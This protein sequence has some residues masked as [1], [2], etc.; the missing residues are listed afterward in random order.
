MKNVH[1]EKMFYS[2]SLAQHIS[3]LSMLGQHL[4]DF[5]LD[6]DSRAMLPSE[7]SRMKSYV[8]QIRQFESFIQP[9]LSDDFYN[10]TKVAK[11]FLARW[12]KGLER[13]LNKVFDASQIVLGCLMQ[14]AH[15]KDLL[16]RSGE[17]TNEPE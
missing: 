1:S 16:Y 10:N 9:S 7:E 4:S 5:Q 13:D 12:K 6:A 8:G 15:N 2:Q 14:E 3:N 17:D 11:M